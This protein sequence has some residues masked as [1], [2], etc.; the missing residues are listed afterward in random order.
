MKHLLIPLFAVFLLKSLLDLIQSLIA[1]EDVVAFQWIRSL[2]LTLLYSSGVP[3]T[4]DRLNI[5]SIGMLWF[6]VA[7]FLGRTLYELCKLFIVNKK[8]ITIVCFGLSFIGYFIAKTCWLP[9]CM[10]IVL[11][12]QPFFYVGDLLKKY[13]LNYIAKKMLLSTGFMWGGTLLIMFL[14]TR[15]WII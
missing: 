11:L 5:G 13:E 10:D 8:A 7:L 4:N 6:V 9:L 1:G 12:I 15:N 14:L 2:L 3:I